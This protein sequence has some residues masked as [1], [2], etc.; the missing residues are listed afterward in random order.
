MH[1]YMI[2]TGYMR[3]VPELKKYILFSTEKEY[4]EFSK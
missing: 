4:R 3:Y 1:G 2:G